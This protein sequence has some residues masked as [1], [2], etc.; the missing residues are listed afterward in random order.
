MNIYHSRFALWT[1]LIQQLNIIIQL[2]SR[3]KI[4]IFNANINDYIISAGGFGLFMMRNG[5]CDDEAAAQHHSN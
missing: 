3:K 5:F 4:I 1:T 2:L